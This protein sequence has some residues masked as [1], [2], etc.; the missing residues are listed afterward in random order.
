MSNSEQHIPDKRDPQE[1]LFIAETTLPAGEVRL[2]KDVGKGLTR[3]LKEVKEDW[4]IVMVQVSHI[5]SDTEAKIEQKKFKLDEITISLG[6]N[7]KGKLAF[8]AEAGIE[9]SVSIK[10]TKG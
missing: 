9:A 7:A 1:V 2:H 6:F 4:D 3:T 5:I 10:F 8:I